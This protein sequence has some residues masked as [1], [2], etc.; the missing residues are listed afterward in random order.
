MGHKVNPNGY[1]LNTNNTWQSL[2]YDR[3]NYLSKIHQDLEIKKIVLEKLTHCGVS[4]II[5]KRPT[6]KLVIN[7]HSSKP[8]LVIG[9]KGEDILKIRKR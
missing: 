3:K 9:K 6:N 2:W 5:I 4:K 7:I 8:G 1:R